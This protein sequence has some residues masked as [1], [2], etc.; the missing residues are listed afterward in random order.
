MATVS[1]TP[2]KSSRPARRPFGAGLGERSPV[3]RSPV[4]ISDLMWWESEAQR[5]QDL[6]IDRLGREYEA[7]QRMENGWNA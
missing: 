1:T 4:A 2:R 6:L 5:E 7:Q 3:Y